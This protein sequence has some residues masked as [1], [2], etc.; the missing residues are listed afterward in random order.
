MIEITILRST[1][2]QNRLHILF[3]KIFH[4]SSSYRS[5]I[6][7]KK[8]NRVPT[9]SPQ[10]KSINRAACADAD[11]A[12]VCPL[13][14]LVIGGMAHLLQSPKQTASASPPDPPNDASLQP[15][16]ASGA[17]GSKRSAHS[18]GGH[19]HSHDRGHGHSHSHGAWRVLIRVLIVLSCTVLF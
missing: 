10:K 4:Y 14:L 11:S 16:T 9:S 6:D 15:R 18:A 13:L 3:Q 17:A 19:G 2:R 12:D 7:S 8:K 5:I 1:T